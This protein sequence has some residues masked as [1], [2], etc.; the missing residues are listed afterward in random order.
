MGRF[1]DESNSNWGNY[2]YVKMN[3]IELMEK[4][5]HRLLKKDPHPRIAISTVTDPYQG[6]ERKYR[7]TRGI[8]KCFAQHKYQGRVSVL[9]K[10]PMVLD[11]V[12]TLNQIPKAEV[13]ISIA[14]SDD[15]LSRKLDAM[16]PLARARL[17]TLQELNEAGI[18]TYV[19]VG[20][21][22][23]HVYLRPD[24][25]DKLFASI[26]NAGTTDIKVEYL[27]IPKHVWPTMKRFL[28]DEPLDVQEIYSGSQRRDYRNQLEPLLRK[29]I[30]R[31]G[32]N[33]RFDE[34]VH[35]AGNQT[36]HEP[37]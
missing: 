20:P 30:T 29:A 35:H 23:P 17:K 22:L 18:K 27:N 1:V 16:A 19:F 14:T 8:L 7:L 3:A 9:T 36:L 32:L 15:A 21:L 6:V 24:L 34:I 5:T 10:S 12:N 33:L 2:V 25:I 28:E 37:N 31:H 26:R 11:D 4:E 13:G